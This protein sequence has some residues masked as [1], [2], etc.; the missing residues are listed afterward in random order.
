MKVEKLTIYI[1]IYTYIYTIDK[2]WEN[3]K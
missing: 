3:K 1:Y 2:Q